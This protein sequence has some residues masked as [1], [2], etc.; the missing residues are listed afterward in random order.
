MSRRGEMNLNAVPESLWR[1]LWPKSADAVIAARKQGVWISSTRPVLDFAPGLIVIPA[2]LYN[3]LG[4]EAY[5]AR[6]W[7][8]FYSI[9]ARIEPR[10]SIHRSYEVYRTDH[11]VFNR[12]NEGSLEESQPDD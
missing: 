4:G 6:V 5:I 7:G 1:T 9:T 11:A 8:E 3:R 12:V 10:R 2:E